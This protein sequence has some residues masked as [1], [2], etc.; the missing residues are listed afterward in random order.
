MKP[1]KL[2]VRRAPLLDLP[3]QAAC[4]STEYS[5]Q[6]QLSGGLALLC[7]ITGQDLLLA[8]CLLLSIDSF[9]IGVFLQY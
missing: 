7:E 9:Y 8:L 6:E 3:L 4:D 1:R 5:H 2:L